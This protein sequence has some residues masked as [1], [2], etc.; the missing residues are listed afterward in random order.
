[1][2]KGKVTISRRSMYKGEGKIFVSIEDRASG[3]TISEL[4]MEFA[5]FAECLT[6]MSYSDADVT[7]ADTDTYQFIGKKRVT[8]TIGIPV[9]AR[10]EKTEE[11]RRMIEDSVP[12]GWMLWSDGLSSQQRKRGIHQF[13]VCKYVV[14]GEE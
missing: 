9:S 6:G 14:E 7:I 13:I 3:L 10:L 5:D 12:D 2:I 1:M 8:E 11:A 4:S